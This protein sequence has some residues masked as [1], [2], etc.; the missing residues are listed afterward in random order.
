MH[1]S[2]SRA[3]LAPFALSA[4]VVVLNPLGTAQV[5]HNGCLA[6]QVLEQTN[7]VAQEHMGQSIAVGGDFNGDG[8][9]DI[10]IG[11]YDRLADG[12]SSTQ[13]Y[14]N[15]V[16]RV[17]VFLGTGGSTSSPP[18]FRHTATIT[19][20]GDV[21]IPSQQGHTDLFGYSVAFIGSAAGLHDNIVVGAPA[22]NGLNG[23]E[24]GRVWILPGST[25]LDVTDPLVEVGAEAWPD[26]VKFDGPVAY[27]WFGKSV[28]T[29][30][31]ASGAFRRELLI[32]APGKGPVNASGA[33][34]GSVYQIGPGTLDSAGAL[35][36]ATPG[37]VIGAAG[38]TGTPGLSGPHSSLPH[39]LMT[40]HRLVHGDNAGDQF[41]HAVAFVGDLD[42]DS[43]QEF[44]VGA[45]QYAGEFPTTEHGQTSSPTMG[46]GYARLFTLGSATP[47]FTFTGC[48]CQVPAGTPPY[49]GEAF[50]F[51]VAGGVD[52]DGD[53]IPDLIIGSP[54]FDADTTGT[55][56]SGLLNAGR[57]SA[58]S[59][60]EAAD[61]TPTA[62]SI[63]G[64]SGPNFTLLVGDSGSNQ[65]GYSV[66]GV[67]DLGND[68]RDDVLVGA[69]EQSKVG[70]TCASGRL[71]LAG[72]ASLLSLGDA[73]PG[74][75]KAIFYGEV[76]K[77]HLGRAV[78]AG[79]LFGTGSKSEIVL[80]GLA[81]SS[82]TV[83]EIGRGYVWDG[84]GVFTPEP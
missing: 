46:T 56:G 82:S 67:A 1:A 65:F 42:G 77:D 68:D 83:G 69:W 7:P 9:K 12:S 36:V 80:S 15:P 72:A 21:W 5:V 11:G 81:W 37:I 43:S 35:S 62:V 4:L 63:F 14:G 25:D 6:T 60:A 19:G 16:T 13:G 23:T 27:G 52:L 73:Q 59:G 17:F 45:P 51:S 31:D 29:A 53:T 70:T 74:T 38:F 47:L 75:A 49:G 61:S 40:P 26:V 84:D 18:L 48:S 32:G 66:T 39:Y 58:F 79:Q 22:Y 41:G 50:G 24:S 33:T 10:V 64:A 3:A 28:A 8:Y 54:L 76:G 44:L 55:V 71:S 57:V 78:A 34:Q 20:L 30:Q 2:G